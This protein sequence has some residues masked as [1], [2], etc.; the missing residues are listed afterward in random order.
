MWA[1]DEEKKRNNG[2]ISS[3]R[4]NELT[5]EDLISSF[6]AILE[7]FDIQPFNSR[8]ADKEIIESFRYLLIQYAEYKPG[9]LENLMEDLGFE[10]GDFSITELLSDVTLTHLVLIYVL[11]STHLKI[12][13]DSK[14]KNIKIEYEL[15]TPKEV[16]KGAVKG[17]LKAFKIE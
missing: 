9:V 13:F 5:N 14:D 8:P 17:I 1:K 15:A 16:V 4:I 12:K 6:N 2:N 10:A 3:L 7:S 11:L